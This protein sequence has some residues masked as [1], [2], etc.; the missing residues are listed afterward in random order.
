MIKKKKSKRKPTKQGLS[1]ISK[2]L[3]GGAIAGG[4]Y[5]LYDKFFAADAPNNNADDENK[6]VDGAT[7]GAILTGIDPGS[8]GKPPI[9]VNDSNK[10][11]LTAIGTPGSKQNWGMLLYK[12]DKGGE[13]ETLQ[14]LFN[15]ISKAYG[16]PGI[17]KD[18]I[19][20]KDTEAKRVAIIGGKPGITLNSV[21][22]LVKNVEAAKSGKGSTKITN[23][24]YFEPIDM[25][26]A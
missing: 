16:K 24:S 21:Y 14:S 11:K 23:K 5:F 1:T 22:K 10:R 18:G 25:M 12:G 9:I 8:G 15:R 3:I 2:V 17:K 7:A 13:I 4:L 26:N 6:V 19:F 20:G